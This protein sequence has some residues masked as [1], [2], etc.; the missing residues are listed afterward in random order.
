MLNS[1]FIFSSLEV[2]ASIVIGTVVH[3]I[4]IILCVLLLIS[5]IDISY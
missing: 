5:Y 2:L 1:E 3:Y 4:Y